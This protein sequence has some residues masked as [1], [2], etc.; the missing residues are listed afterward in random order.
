M[1][2]SGTAHYVTSGEQDAF[3]Y[4][5]DLLSYLPPITTPGRHAAPRRCRP[6]DR[7]NLTDEDLDW[8]R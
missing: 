5:R 7:G 2:K 8:T 1:A 3:D 6:G 4:V